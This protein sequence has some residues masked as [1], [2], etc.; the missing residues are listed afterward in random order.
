MA[1][2]SLLVSDFVLAFMWVWAGALVKLFVYGFLG[3]GHRPEGEALKI[4]LTVL[5]MFFFAGLEKVTGGGSYNPL[6][7][8]ASSIM[9][10]LD[11][12][13]FTAFGRIP[14]QVVGAI[15]GVKL[16]RETFPELGHGPRLNV[17]IH[18]GAL[19]EGLA[20]FLIVMVSVTLKK[21][22]PNSFFMKTWISSISKM[23]LHILSSDLTGG[24]MNPA[25]AFAW[26]Y[27]RGDHVTLDHLF[28]YWLAPLQATLLGVWVVKLSTKPEKSKKQ[29]AE[30][31]K[32]KSD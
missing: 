27:A 21:K 23:A 19:A 28:V 24:I 5:Y 11:G 31:H 12:Y 14:A 22:D 1:R 4:A 30:E 8:L 29:G 17:E 15:L 16:I 3:I 18:H 7:A 20:T 2:I 26:A 9:A 25:S 6:T 32:P 13:L 10:K